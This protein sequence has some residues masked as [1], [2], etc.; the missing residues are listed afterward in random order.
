[1]HLPE[2]EA[3]SSLVI[4]LA[5]SGGQKSLINIFEQ[6]K[7]INTFNVQVSAYNLASGCG[8][9]SKMLFTYYDLIKRYMKDGSNRAPKE[10]TTEERGLQR[11]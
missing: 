5:A 7:R 11:K 10:A 8:G 4:L 1:M 6:A 9:K 2:D 3:C